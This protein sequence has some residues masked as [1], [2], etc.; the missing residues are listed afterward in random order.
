MTIQIVRVDFVPSKANTVIIGK[1][2]KAD[3]RV[4][5]YRVPVKHAPMP[6]AVYHHEPINFNEPF[7]Q[8]KLK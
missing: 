7:A 2:I 5:L 4:A 1:G 3:G 8:L 6:N